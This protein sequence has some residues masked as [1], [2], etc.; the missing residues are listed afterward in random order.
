MRPDRMIA[1][2]EQEPQLIRKNAQSGHLFLLEVETDQGFYSFLLMMRAFI[3]LIRNEEVRRVWDHSDD[4][5]TMPDCQMN[6][7]DYCCRQGRCR[8]VGYLFSEVKGGQQ[9][10]HKVS[11]R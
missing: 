6:A 9:L 4:F 2:E 5:T 3:R 11:L 1:K 8:A 7:Q 10:H